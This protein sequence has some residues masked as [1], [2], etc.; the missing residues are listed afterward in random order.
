MDFFIISVLLA[1]KHIISSWK[2]FVFKGK[3]YGWYNLTHIPGWSLR[4]IQLQTVECI[5]WKTTL[6]IQYQNAHILTGSHSYSVC[7]DTIKRNLANK[8]RSSC[9]FKQMFLRHKTKEISVFQAPPNCLQRCS[10][11]PWHNLTKFMITKLHFRPIV[12]NS[13]PGR[14]IS[15]CVSKWQCREIQWH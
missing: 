8:A 14:L 12:S 1:I 3:R 4:V 7:A 13:T 10:N 5:E 11:R 6:Y 9:C 2:G 15:S